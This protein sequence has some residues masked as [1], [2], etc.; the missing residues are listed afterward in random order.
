VKLALPRGRSALVLLVR[1]GLAAMLA[2]A[3]ASK[4][5]GPAS[6]AEDIQNYRVLPDAWAGP[7]ALGLPVLELVVAAGLILPSH[8]AG[9]SLLSGLLL[10]GFAAAMAQAKVRGIDLECGCFGGHSRVSWSKVSLNVGLAALAFAAAAVHVARARDSGEQ[11][12]SP[13]G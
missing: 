9:A 1:L 6:F 8:A 5:L 3:G 2:Y 10:L 7:L 12:V 4:L 13:P 11:L